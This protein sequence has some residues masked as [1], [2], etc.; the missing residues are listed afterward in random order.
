MEWGNLKTVSVVGLS[1]IPADILI[2]VV[3]SK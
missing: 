2:D 1:D 3:E